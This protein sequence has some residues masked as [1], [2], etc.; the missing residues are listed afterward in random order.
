MLDYARRRKDDDARARAK[1]MIDW[2]C[3]IQLPGGGFQGG[4]IGVTPVVPVTFNSGQ[5]LF[6]LAAGVS[7]W[8]DEYEGSLRAA[9]NW[10]VQTQDPDG[11]WRTHPSPFTKSGEKSYET[12]VAW[13]LVEAERVRPGHG[14]YEAALANVRWAI[15]QQQVNG[16]YAKCGLHDHDAPLTHTIG[17][18]L[19]GC[20]EVFRFGHEPELLDAATRA[21]DG[22]L[23]TLGAEG[24]L[25]GRLDRNWRGTVDWVCVTGT[26]QIAS[27]WFILYDLTRKR[28]YLDAARSAN[29]FVRSTIRLDGPSDVKGAVKGSHPVDGGYCPYWYLNWA[30]KFALDAQFHEIDH[31]T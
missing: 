9:A 8:G 19:R 26:A 29:A 31:S 15:A 20:L 21:A 1:R 12:H 28:E 16:W 30:A 5:I 4:T 6:A 10:L 22:L 24:W 27:C 2:L 23:S 11:C 17:Y 25:A 18:A 7:E 3:S 13:A 14:Y